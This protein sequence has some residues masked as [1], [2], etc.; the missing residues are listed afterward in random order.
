MLDF[1]KVGSFYLVNVSPL[2]IDTEHVFNLVN[3]QLDNQLKPNTALLIA[4]S[5]RRK[6]RIIYWD[7]IGFINIYKEYLPGNTLKVPNEDFFLKELS[8]DQVYNFLS[9]NKIV[10]TKDLDVSSFF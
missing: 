9:C 5:H 1:K 7:G 6:L 10:R 8:I 4:S 3:H 2:K